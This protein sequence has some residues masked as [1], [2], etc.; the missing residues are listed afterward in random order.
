MFKNKFEV[1]N[2]TITI[3]TC[4]Y[5]SYL[6]VEASGKGEFPM[7]QLNYKVF[8]FTPEKDTSGIL[9]FYKTNL[10]NTHKE[11]PHLY[12]YYWENG[13]LLIDENIKK[14][15]RQFSISPE[16]GLSVNFSGFCY[17][18]IP[19]TGN[20]NYKIIDPIAMVNYIAGEIGAKELCNNAR[21]VKRAENRFKTQKET[22][23]RQ[24]TQIKEADEKITKLTTRLNLCNL[25]IKSLSG[26]WW[27]FQLHP[28]KETLKLI[29]ELKEHEKQFGV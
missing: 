19:P 5:Y 21:S 23:S 26:H 28:K 9:L 20:H 6:F 29:I 11:T 13:K 2:G 4:S 14:F 3:I 17:V 12:R 24:E 22:I 8:T 27:I 25:I 15:P 18:I 16:I 1:K 10:F 7:K